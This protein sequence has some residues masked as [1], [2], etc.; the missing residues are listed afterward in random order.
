MSL[1]EAI[2]DELAVAPAMRIDATQEPPHQ[3]KEVFGR[4]RRLHDDSEVCRLVLGGRGTLVVQSFYSLVYEV[5]ERG[6]KMLIV[7]DAAR[8]H[9]VHDEGARGRVARG[10]EKIVLVLLHCACDVDGAFA[11]LKNEVGDEGGGIGR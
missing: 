5:Y 6:P 9:P 7:V 4:Q 8:L 11:K 3:L 10:P 1:D 2:D